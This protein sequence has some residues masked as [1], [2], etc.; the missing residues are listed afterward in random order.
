MDYKF[1]S[2]HIMYY[3]IIYRVK[4][5]NKVYEVYILQYI[6]TAKY[7]ITNV[8]CHITGTVRD[9]QSLLLALD[10]AVFANGIA[11]GDYI[12]LYRA[13]RVQDLASIVNVFSSKTVNIHNLNANGS[14]VIVQ[15]D[16][17]ISIQVDEIE[18]FWTASFTEKCID[19]KRSLRREK[20]WSSNFEESSIVRLL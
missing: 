1:H 20:C 9:N 5:A 10:D 16:R 3:A 11:F 14:W 12:C 6:H 2:L 15:T 18:S 13:S 8:I 19:N 7:Y 4:V 17:E